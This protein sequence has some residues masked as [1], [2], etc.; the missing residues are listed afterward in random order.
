MDSDDEVKK[1]NMCVVSHC[2]G[3][4]VLSK[5]MCL[6]FQCVLDMDSGTYF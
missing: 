1:N 6:R 2:L 4:D 5:A 3:K